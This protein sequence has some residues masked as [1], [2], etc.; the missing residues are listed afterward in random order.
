MGGGRK[1]GRTAR[2]NELLRL[3]RPYVTTYTTLCVCVCT[4]VCMP[5]CIYMCVSVCVCV[6][7]DKKWSPCPPGGQQEGNSGLNSR[8]GLWD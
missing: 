3:E 7:L 4:C 5:V 2:K 8:G 6:R 1:D